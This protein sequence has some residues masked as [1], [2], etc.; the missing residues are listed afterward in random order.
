MVGPRVDAAKRF[1]FLFVAVTA[2]AFLSACDWGQL[3]YGSEH[4][5]SSPDNTVSKSAVQSGSLLPDWTA[6]TGGAGVSSPAISGGVAFV[7]ARDERLYAFD[8]AGSTGCAGA[9][10]T[11]TPLWTSGPL[12]E[13]VRSSP[14]A[15]G[16]KVYVSTRDGQLMAFDSTGTASCS[17]APKVCS[18][19]WTA[20]LPGKAI[21][22]PSVAGGRAYIVSTAT[23]ADA[24][25][26][27]DAGSGAPLWSA[28]IANQSANGHTK[29]AATVANGI[30]YVGFT[31]VSDNASEPAQARVLAFDANGSIGCSGTPKVCQ[32]LWATATDIDVGFMGTPSVA[33]GVMYA[34]G[35]AFDAVGV[36]G[37]SGTPK[38]CTPMWAMAGDGDTGVT[39]GVV[40]RGASA[41]DAKGVTS[42]AGV[43]KICQ[44]LWTENIGGDVVSTVSIASG[45]VYVSAGDS[46]G[47][48]ES[49]LYAFDALG[50]AGCSGVP[51][52][53]EPLW[54]ANTGGAGTAATA[55]SP[56]VI[57]EGRVYLGSIDS[58]LYAYALEKIPPTVSLAAPVS[59]DTVGDVTVLNATAADNVAVSKLEFQVTGGDVTNALLGA[60]TQTPSGWLFTWNPTGLVDGPYVLA[61]IA[62]DFAGNQ[63][64]S[65]DVPVTVNNNRPPLPETVSADS[66][67]TVQVT[68]IVWAQ[69]MVGNTVYATGNF[70]K[71][72][73]AGAAAGVNE[74][75]R[76]DLLAYD[77]T[78]GVLLPFNHTLNGEG[79]AIAG[80][81]DGSRIYVGGSFTT[82]DGASHPRLAAFNT[83]DGSLVTSF[84]GGVNGGIRAV[85][86]T[87]TAVYVGGAFSAAGPAPS[88]TRLAGFS[89]AGAL[90]DWNPTA[91]RT[92]A[93]MVMSPDQSKVIFG[94][95]FGTVNGL[96]Y[97]GMA[98]ADAVTGV[99]SPW[100]SQSDSYAIKLDGTNAGVTTLST[101]GTKVFLGGFDTGGITTPGGLEG[102]AA[103]S[104]TDGTV[105]WIS[106]C[107]GDTYSTAPVGNILYSVGHA[108]DCQPIGAF[109]DTEPRVWHRALAETSFATQLNGPPTNGYWGY[110]GTPAPTPLDWYP[111]V[112]T[113]NFS[114][115]TQGGWSVVANSSYL[116]MGGEFTKVNGKAQQALARFAIRSLAPNKVG[117]ATYPA[118]SVLAGSAS[119]LGEL[120]V[121]WK[122]TW[123]K[124]DAVLTY[125][126]FRDGA[127]TPIFTADA[128][129]RFWRTPMM[130]FTD[131]GLAPG[132]THAYRLVVT[133]PWGNTVATTT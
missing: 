74:V 120:P 127:T 114:G 121:S 66:L 112:N 35:L 87:N 30:A 109:P 123:D 25:S 93:A 43:P 92:V 115:A 133:D 34:S 126:L 107:H 79:R 113:G 41:F 6:V 111:A 18:P 38:R 23:D 19:V 46:T 20:T 102:R 60:A 17:G 54:T 32:P 82:V 100:G 130:A 63:T 40:F 132:S 88:R 15:G 85:T 81:P 21:G 42:C 91:D 108:H 71:A 59:G 106:D 78:T 129:S 50:A 16:G 116:A 86:A 62:T 99:P 101:N 36:S 53:C 2:V 14:A 13:F 5:G 37:C 97:H 39:K 103:F 80:S 8:A 69:A 124:D 56:P 84:T 98:A 11:C 51:L 26:V 29:S 96:T 33:D 57:S 89:S 65:A 128:D 22:S 119:G 75:T 48:A 105:G 55:T 10:K 47:A 45:V 24:I 4:T 68:G 125:R 77:V 104:P 72:R 64:R 31:G 52:V 7:V 3:G 58:K 117:P 9:P 94:G 44:P 49:H 95:S 12:G 73:P 27:F 70:T 90:L 61:A 83:A 110:E 131:S 28:T 67:P 122:T 1:G 118:H 76:T